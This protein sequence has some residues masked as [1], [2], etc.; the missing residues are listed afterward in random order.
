[1]F[2]T[3][4]TSF[5]GYSWLAAMDTRDK[6]LEHR[7]HVLEEQTRAFSSML[8]AVAKHAVNSKERGRAL[9]LEQEI[10]A[11]LPLTALEKIQRVAVKALVTRWKLRVQLM[12]DS[13]QP[14]TIV[15][16]YQAGQAKAVSTPSTDAIK[17]T[18]KK[19][20]L[21]VAAAAAVSASCAKTQTTS[22]LQGNI[23]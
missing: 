3:V 11:V 5:Q 14:K 12:G 18:K 17:K 16:K 19:L 15:T 4:D 7:M 23:G 10:R 22:S 2:R 6:I 20:Q 9:A 13:I 21:K 1:M 8:P